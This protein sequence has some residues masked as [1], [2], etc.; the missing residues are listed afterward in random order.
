MTPVGRPWLA[1]V[2]IAC[3]AAG[4]LGA[5]AAAAHVG[6]PDTWFEGKAGP[7]PIRVVVRAPGVVPGLAQID[8]RVLE[9]SA[10]H[11]TAQPFIWNAGEGGAPPADEAKAV[12][13]EPHLYN[14]S[15]W[16]M[17]A[18][19]YG[20]HVTV[21]GDRGSGL[22]VVPVQ[23][24]ATR[25]LPMDA[26]LR[27]TLAGL[28]AFLFVGLVTIIGA[29]VG[30]ST[31]PPGEEPDATR[32]RRA[33]IV[34][35]VSGLVLALA[36]FGGRSWWD[37]VD[38]AFAA[39]L[40]RPFHATAQVVNAAGAP[41]LRLTIDDPRWQGPRWTPLLSDHGKLMHL[42][43]VREAD[44][45]AIA[46]LHPLAGDST[47]FET[48]LPALPPGRYRVYADIVHESGFAQTLTTSVDLAERS[49]ETAAPPSDPDDSWFIGA[50][51]AAAPL[52][53]ERFPLGDGSA[54]VW[55]R[56]ADPIVAGAD[57]PLRFRVTAAD[58][59]PATL[60]AYLGMAAHAMVTTPDGSVFAHLHPIGT[61]SMAAEMALTM[62]TPA[63]SL[64]GTLGRR[65]AMHDMSGHA[66][67]ADAALAGEFSIPYGFP[68]SGRYRVWVQ[69]KRAGVV[70]TAVFDTDVL[71][72][73]RPS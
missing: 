14:V 34:M 10:R 38:R 73:P 37:D 15:L 51:A 17:A 50:P 70:R 48:R 33:R 28:L 8:V 35:A 58:G 46:H 9:G 30:D 65:L 27:W 4:T 59:T 24:M 60:E 54:L 29:S 53:E 3:F 31:L 56:G 12:P 21:S 72:A 64:A 55:E 68:K 42:F 45:G 52:A 22:A 47:R 16:L 13:G 43:L 62:R 39:D 36:L 49:S 66:M 40:Y 69:V 57:R 26:G 1:L 63:D 7:Y 23:A 61:V 71:P 19:S 67:S 44:L 20:V 18:G 41:S 5:G 6:S 25:R 2:G 11:V 32:R